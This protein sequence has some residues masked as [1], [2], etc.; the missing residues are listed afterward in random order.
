MDESLDPVLF[1]MTLRNKVG[2]QG[3]RLNDKRYTQ[4]QDEDELMLPQGTSVYVLGVEN[5]FSKQ[6]NQDIVTIHLYNNK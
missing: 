5:N 2:F 1:C 4:Y 6:F 3:I